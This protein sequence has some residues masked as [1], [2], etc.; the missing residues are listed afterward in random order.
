MMRV[1]WPVCSLV[2]LSLLSS[3]VHAQAPDK[4]TVSVTP[5]ANAHSHNDYEHDR[6]LLDALD[7]GF[8]SIEAD[9]FLFEGQLLVT[10]DALFHTD[11]QPGHRFRTER[12]VATLPGPFISIIEQL[13]LLIHVAGCLIHRP[14]YDALT[15]ARQASAFDGPRDHFV[16]QLF[17]GCLNEVMRLQ[18]QLLHEVGD[19]LWPKVEFGVV[20]HPRN[21]SER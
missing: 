21:L 11:T 6:P 5:L 15:I 19:R 4:P 7:H 16:S 8:T 17:G 9:I 1:L 14:L 18:L 20:C 12:D 3:P 10:H 2:A 13:H